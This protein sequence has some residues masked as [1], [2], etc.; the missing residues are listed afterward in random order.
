MYLFLAGFFIQS[1]Q[2][3]S[4]PLQFKPRL[5][6][7]VLFRQFSQCNHLF[8][9]A[10]FTSAYINLNITKSTFYNINNCLP[11]ITCIWLPDHCDCLNLPQKTTCW[12]WIQGKVSATSTFPP[13]SSP[14][15]RPFR[16]KAAT[17]VARDAAAHVW[18]C[19]LRTN[20]AWPE[21]G[22]ELLKPSLSGAGGIL[23]CRLHT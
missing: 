6:P 10:T 7:T 17:W 18:V 22:G 16:V 13:S 12:T 15:D 19:G 23:K 11:P 2:G 5:K 1:T 4:V 14:C 20:P 3:S 8:Y 9:F 21:T